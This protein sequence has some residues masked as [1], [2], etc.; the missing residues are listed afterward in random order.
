MPIMLRSSN[1]VLTG[2]TP[3]EFAKLNECPLDPG[4]FALMFFLPICA[5]SFKSFSAKKCSIGMFPATVKLLW[6]LLKCVLV[7]KRNQ[8]AFENGEKWLTAWNVCICRWNFQPQKQYMKIL[9]KFR[10]VYSN[11]Q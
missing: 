5:F 1:C 3:A 10:S 7:T 9:N 4:T 2:K 6:E 8:Q 11:V